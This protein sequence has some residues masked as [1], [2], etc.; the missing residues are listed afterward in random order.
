MTHTITIAG[1]IAILLALAISLVMA[2]EG[3]TRAYYI[4]LFVVHLAA[5]LAFWAITLT[6]RSDPHLYY[7]HGEWTDT[8]GLG[9]KF[10]SYL[11]W[12]LRRWLDISYL[13][14][15]LFFQIPGLVGI[16][17]LHKAATRLA[18]QAFQTRVAMLGFL[19][20]LPGLQF[21]TASIGKDS[22]AILAYGLIALALSTR[23]L[24]WVPLIAGFMI[25]F[26]VRPHIAFILALAMALAF[27]PL[28]GRS[29]RRAIVVGLGASVAFALM[30]PFIF[31]FVGIEENALSGVSDFIA[32]RQALGFRGGSGFDLNELS[33][34]ERVF[35]VWFR[36]LFFDAEGVNAIIASVENLLLIGIF[37]FLLT[38]CRLL[39][40][41][42]AASEVLRF[43]AIFL[44]LFTLVLSQTTGNLGL[45]LRQ[46]M[47]ALPA[48][49]LLFTAVA[50]HLNRRRE[51]RRDG[52]AGRVE[53]RLAKATPGD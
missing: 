4:L 42:M 27:L 49:I 41:L 17:L 7:R 32:R 53:A 2:Q 51:L 20:L 23:P 26:M 3:R 5:A 50:A 12:V 35:T 9:T 37:A 33:A 14:G 52:L 38:H 22:L 40:R 48:L 16:I 29:H 44:V 21:W 11:T 25:Y 47:M 31:F 36:P 10:I 1:I 24:G 13:D 8:I 15:F 43:H 34:I 19:L 6:V 30:L 39:F 45:A 18:G 28:F 46:K